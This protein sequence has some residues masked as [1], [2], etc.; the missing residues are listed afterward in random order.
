[1]VIRFLLISDVLA[2][3]GAAYALYVVGAWRLVTGAPAWLRGPEWSR[4]PHSIALWSFG[5]GVFALYWFVS[6]RLFSAHTGI[7]GG[8]V[9][10]ILGMAT[11]VCWL[12]GF[13]RSR[14]LSQG[15]HR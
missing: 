1:M 13:G 8:L 10:A 5:W 9:A 12:V 15:G 14:T 4:T 7:V 11:I 6:P 3:L 2:A